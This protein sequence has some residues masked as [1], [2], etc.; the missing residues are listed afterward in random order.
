MLLNCR[1]IAFTKVRA[2][3]RPYVLLFAPGC[4]TL[5]GRDLPHPKPCGEA[6]SI[7]DRRQGKTL[8]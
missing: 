1:F 6:G 5:D 2:A 4:R 8:R 3:S 7:Y